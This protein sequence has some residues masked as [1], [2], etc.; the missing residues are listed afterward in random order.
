MR[1]VLK[2]QLFRRPTEEMNGYSHRKD[3]WRHDCSDGEAEQQGPFC[4]L[5]RGTNM[6][7]VTFS[8]LDDVAAFLRANPGSGVRMHP[9]S[10]RII[11]HI[12]IDGVP[13]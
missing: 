11:E 5:S 10:A 2:P 13:R 3:C 7:P 4:M 12:H 6:D 8:N 1:A 9:G